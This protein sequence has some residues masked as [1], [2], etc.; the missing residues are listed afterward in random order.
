MAGLN[1]A[2]LTSNRG[3]VKIIEIVVGIIIASFLCGTWGDTGEK[4]G[5]N[6]FYEGRIGSVSG[7]NFVVLIVNVVL[8][9]INF[10]NVSVWRMEKLY[11]VVCAVLFLIAAIVMV[12]YILIRDENRNFMWASTA[13]LIGEFFLFVWDVKILQGEAFN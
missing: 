10:L 12:W 4:L 9:V 8:F 5:R 6:C 2:Y 13:L 7:F 3:L 1:T 11:S